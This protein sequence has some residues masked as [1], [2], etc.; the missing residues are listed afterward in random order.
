MKQDFQVGD[1][2]K[3]EIIGQVRYVLVRQDGG[4]EYQLD[5]GGSS[6]PLGWIPQS[7][8]CALVTPETK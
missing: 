7:Q 3:A 2:V 6:V 5:N 1:W 8:V 4:V